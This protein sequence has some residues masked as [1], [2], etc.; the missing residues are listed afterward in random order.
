[1]SA[2]TYKQIIDAVFEQITRGK[3]ALPRLDPSNVAIRKFYNRDIP[4]RLQIGLPGIFIWH[5]EQS[6]DWLQQGTNVSE[7]YGYPVGISMFA[8]DRVSGRQSQTLDHDEYLLWRHNI[9]DHFVRRRLP[10]VPTVFDCEYRPQSIMDADAW[11]KRNLWLSEFV[12]VFLSRE[13]KSSTSM[14]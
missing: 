1:M 14:T 2:S 11:K 9:R 7:D 12:L 3:I 5:D 6:E 8:N 10:A 13:L 4:E